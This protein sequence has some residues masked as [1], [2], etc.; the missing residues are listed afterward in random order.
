MSISKNTVAIERAVLE[1][2]RRVL[3]LAEVLVV[4]GLDVRRS[5]CR[6]L[7]IVDVHLSAAGFIAT[8]TSQIR[9]G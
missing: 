4:E 7:E 8:S 6:R 3:G 2:V 5:P 9:R 1:R